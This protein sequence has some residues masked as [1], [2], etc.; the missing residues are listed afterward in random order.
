M[1]IDKSA[2]TN[3]FNIFLVV[4]LTIISF[5]FIKEAFAKTFLQWEAVND[6]HIAE[7]TAMMTEE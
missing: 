2:K 3:W 5:W 6:V 4:G 7:V 1:L